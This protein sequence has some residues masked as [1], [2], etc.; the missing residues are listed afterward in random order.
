MLFLL[1]RMATALVGL[2]IVAGPA[3]AQVG[4][5]QNSTEDPQVVGFDDWTT[6]P[7]WTVGESVRTYTPPGIPDGIGAIKLNDRVVRIFLNHELGDGVGYPYTLANGTMLTGARVSFFDVN[8]R[9]R[10]LIRSSL[11]YRTVIDRYG[12]VVTSATQINEGADPL[13][14][15]NRLCSAALFT[16]GEYG[17]VDD[18][19]F[20]G[21]ETGGGQEFALDVHG[22]VLH[23]APWLGRAAWEN[24]TLLDTRELNTVAVL[25]GD[26]RGGAP[27]LLYV[28]VKDPTGGFLARN[29]LAGGTL[30]VW[31]TDSGETTPD[32]WNGTGTSRTGRFVP[33]RHYDALQAGQPG[34]DA[35]GFADQDT[36]DALAAAR[37]A[38]RFSRP[39]DVATNPADGSQAVLAS[40][41][42]GGLFPADNWGT[43]YLIDVDFGTDLVANGVINADA[44]ITGELTVLYDGDDAGDG[45]FSDPDFGLR[46]PD[47]LDWAD[48]GFIYVQEDRS[49]SP[50]SLFGGTSGEDASIWRLNPASPEVFAAADLVR[51]AQIDIDAVPEGQRE[52]EPQPNER[53]V[54]ETSGILDVTSLF[55]T[56]PGEMLFLVDVQAHEASAGPISDNDLVEGGQL[57]FLSSQSSPDQASAVGASLDAAPVA[58]ALLGSAPNPTRDRTTV[59]FE[60]AE[61]GDVTVAVFDALGREVARLLDGPAEAGV[62]QVTFDVTGLPAGVYVVRMTTE[63]ATFAER[64]T[65]VR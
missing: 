17:L 54:R 34:Y 64:I 43:T 19:F 41:G 35:Q 21:E 20:T 15:I 28:G 45:A 3:L 39:E 23:T 16:A 27:L 18:I 5:G 46:S 56:R 12:E 52:N 63:T 31:V 62:R 8:S 33:I 48:D 50:A 58:D 14:G 1:P 51:I 59:G 32:E 36:Q 25:I 40:T 44:F 65:V 29:G 60:L 13:D 7:I 53:G 42:R 26:D 22:R 61:A 38:F 49:T 6:T 30:F 55:R 37:G 57:L 24:V 9:S 47:N 11:A 10:N 2:A 4:D